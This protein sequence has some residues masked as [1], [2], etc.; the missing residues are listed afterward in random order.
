MNA[1]SLRGFWPRSQMK[2]SRRS[3]AA[4]PA[5]TADLQSGEATPGEMDKTILPIL[6]LAANNPH[7][8]AVSLFSKKPR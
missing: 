1:I 2:N 5:A 3:E 4:K 7:V 6:D 8:I